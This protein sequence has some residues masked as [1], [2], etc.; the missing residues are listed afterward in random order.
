M[1]GA[2]RFCQLAL[3]PDR[4][5]FLPTCDEKIYMCSHDGDGW[6]KCFLKTSPDLWAWLVLVHILH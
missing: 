1:F 3:G 6:S 4:K 2:E 5:Q